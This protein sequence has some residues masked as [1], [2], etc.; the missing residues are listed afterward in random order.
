MSNVLPKLNLPR[1]FENLERQANDA[2]IDPF[3]IVE[4]VDDAANR[5]DEL[6]D[7]VRTSGGLFEVIFGESGSGKTT[8]VRSLPKFYNNV[9]I[10]VFDETED[11]AQLSQ[12]ISSSYV[13]GDK[14]QRVVVIQGRDNPEQ[15]DLR[16]G[17][18]ALRQLLNLFRRKDGQVVLLWTITDREAAKE[19]SETAW[20]IGRDSMVDF[21]TRGI[22]EFEG[23]PKDRWATLADRTSQSLNGDKLDAFGLDQDAISDFLSQSPTISIFF[24]RATEH[25]NTIRNG[26]WSV[27][28]QTI[29]PHVW[30]VLASD[31]P[32]ST[33]STTTGLTQGAR[34][35]VDIEL[36]TEYLD[37]PEGG[38][39]YVKK[40]RERKERLAHYL[41]AIDLRIFDL[42]PNVSLAAVRRFGDPGLKEKLNQR[43]V[44]L[45]LAKNAMRA[46]RLYKAILDLI[47]IS[48]QP[49]IAPK[50][51]KADTADEYI[52]VQQTAS[53]ND[54]PLNR[55]VAMLLAACL[56]DDLVV[57]EVVAEKQELPN[58][59]LK[60]DIQIRTPSGEY[61]CIELTWRSSGRK[62]VGT[63][64]S[65]Q[66][67]SKTGHMKKYMLDK[68][69]DFIVGLGLS[70]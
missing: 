32:V 68:A 6:L 18:V 41:R 21:S 59:S 53:D 7:R 15:K 37:A 28:K 16:D 50:K 44:P 39:N 65:S 45:D 22:F 42:P 29:V 49:Y 66:D 38:A 57:C 55:A 13:E 62:V 9:K 69:D 40:W 1:R 46:T 5:I 52:R 23:V 24:A 33:H 30:V 56:K 34:S 8:F 26:T 25:A 60:P 27:L 3:E 48:S 67:T 61:I 19:I 43:S 63:R 36:I 47:G 70:E 31:D 11:L 51:V 64:S 2:Q 17:K 10:E 12:W 35:R 14:R 4:R 20:N 58:C 54:K